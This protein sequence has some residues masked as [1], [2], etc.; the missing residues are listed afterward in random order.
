MN[1]SKNNRKIEFLYNIT[2][3]FEAGA[4]LDAISVKAIR[5]NRYNINTSFVIVDKY[6]EVWLRNA[7]IHGDTRDI[8]L[9]LRKKEISK[10][11]G[12]YSVKS[13]TIKPLSV[14]RSKKYYKITIGVCIAKNMIDKREKIKER[15]IQRRGHN[16]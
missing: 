12:Y 8:K 16:E 2:H 15:D 14:I 3:K 11:F 1:N 5:E 7:K 10:L 9:L 6:H 13:I 4:V